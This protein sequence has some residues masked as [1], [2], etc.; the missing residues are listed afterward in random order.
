MKTALPVSPLDTVDT[1]AT[2]AGPRERWNVVAATLTRLVPDDLLALASRLSIAGIFFLSG[3]TKV[4]G[5]LMVTD[6]AYDLFRNEYKLPLVPP[7]LAAHLAAYAEHLFPLLLVLGLFTRL[8]ALSLLA[9]TLVIQL[10]VYP[11]AWP[12]HLSWAA[13]LLYLVGRGGGRM[14][15]DRMLRIG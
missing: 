2:G 12:T 11:S 1:P 9:M 15:L 3:R 6:S 7:E 14:A 8:S 10:F 4:E 13:L 5:F